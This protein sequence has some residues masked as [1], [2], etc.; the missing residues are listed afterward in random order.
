M[1]RKFADLI[2]DFPP[3]RLDRIERR[4]KE[5]EK[6][7]GVRITSLTDDAIFYDTGEQEGVYG[8]GVKTVV[9]IREDVEPR[10]EEH[11]W[12]AEVERITLDDEA[13][14][15]LRGAL[16]EIRQREKKEE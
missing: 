2:R 4:K 10:L 7:M 11:R 6:D 3:E 8:D 14:A 13:K 1:T 12:P 5:L 15:K 16:A 9:S